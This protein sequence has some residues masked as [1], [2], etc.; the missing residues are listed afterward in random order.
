MKKIPC[1]ESLHAFGETWNFTYVYEQNLDPKFSGITSYSNMSVVV[2]LN[3]PEPLP[4]KTMLHELIHLA[5]NHT[6][7]NLTEEQVM[8]LEHGLWAILK[9]NP[10]VLDWIFHG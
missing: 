10:H 9:D 3:Q 6:M 4:R 5:S 8:Q 2:L 1:P 7:A